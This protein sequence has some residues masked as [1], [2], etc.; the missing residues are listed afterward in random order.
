MVRK[1]T[2]R[3]S[4]PGF[5]VER[6]SK[7]KGPEKSSIRCPLISSYL[8]LFFDSLSSFT[9]LWPVLFLLVVFLVLLLVFLLLSSYLFDLFLFLSCLCR[10]HYT[11]FYFSVGEARGCEVLC[12]KKVPLLVFF[13]KNDRL[14]DAFF[15]VVF[16]SLTLCYWFLSSSLIKEMFH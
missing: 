4:R 5:G 1:G 16:A 6:L 11:F 15:G 9:Q 2:A 13:T 10:C 14:F 7:F 12:L 8:H 3:I